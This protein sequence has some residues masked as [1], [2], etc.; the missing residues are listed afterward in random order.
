MDR[1]VSSMGKNA[2]E[3]RNVGRMIR[4]LLVDDHKILRDGL[5]ALLEATDDV[6]VVATASHAEEA[7]E[8]LRH[9]PDLVVLDI[10]LPDKDGIWL[11]KE[12]RKHKPDLCRRVGAW[13]TSDPRSSGA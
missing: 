1:C 4:V 2:H 9:D 13:P 11:A 7:L 3:E 6:Q 10:S 8:K 5:K 12:I